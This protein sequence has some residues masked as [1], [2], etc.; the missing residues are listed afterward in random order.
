MEHIYKNITLLIILLFITS[1]TDVVEV[2]TPVGAPRLI[3]EASIDVEKGTQGNTQFIKLSESTPYF[4]S[5]NEA[6]VVDAAVKII[7][8]T[9]NAEFIFTHTNNGIYATSNFIPVFNQS[10]TLEIIY[11]NETYIAE[12][13]L[14]P[15]VEIDEV[16]QSIEG[17]FNEEVLEANIF[18]NDPLDVEN[19]YFFRFEEEGDLLPELLVI[20][21]RFTDGNRMRVFFEKSNDDV[22]NQD[23]FKTGDNVKMSFHGISEHYF[24]YLDILISQYEDGGNPFGTIP[25]AIKGNCLNTTNTDNYAFGYFRLSEVIYV[26]YTFQ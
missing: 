23:E 22:I 26:N 20:P 19:Y 16:S 25:S 3:V 14:T 12:E 7:N 17:G 4:D 1:C 11:N 2:D 24:N 15:V 6:P 13:T 21:D 10:Y 18:F 8:N 5:S 9:T